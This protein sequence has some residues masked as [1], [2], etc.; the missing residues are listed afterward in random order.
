MFMK[1]PFFVDDGREVIVIQLT[2]VGVMK[3]VNR[4]EFPN[5]SLALRRRYTVC[6]MCIYYAI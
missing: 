5:W 2:I 3:S 1:T 6:H 4:N